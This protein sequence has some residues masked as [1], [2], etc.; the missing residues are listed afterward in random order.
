[1]AYASDPPGLRLL[2]GHVALYLQ[3]LPRVRHQL[4]GSVLYTGL[5]AYEHLVLIADLRSE[6]GR[7]LAAKCA[8][9]WPLNERLDEAEQ[10][11]LIPA[12]SR[13]EPGGCTS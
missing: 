13:A 1:M 2:P 11:G 5:Q 12:C 6:M 9:G 3:E 10:L 7:R 8:P 4:Y